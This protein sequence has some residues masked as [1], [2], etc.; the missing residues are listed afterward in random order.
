MLRKIVLVFGVLLILSAGNV[1]SASESI[2][3]NSFR[4]A[5]EKATD[6]FVELKNIGF[7]PVNI[8]GWQLAKKTASGTKYNLVTSFPSLEIMPGA[9]FVVG[10]DDSTNPTDLKYSSGN[11]ISEDNTIIIFS[12]AGKT[13]VDKVGFGKASDFEGVALPSAKTGIWTRRNSRDTDNNAADFVAEAT[14]LP[15]DLS[16]IQVTEIMIAPTDGNEWIEIYN[17]GPTIDIS[18]LVISD[19][20][21]SIRKYSVSPNTIIEHGGFRVF[22][23]TVTKISLNNTGDG[24]RLSAPDGTEIDNSGNSGPARPGQAYAFDGMLW[25][26]TAAPTPGA[27]NIFSGEKAT[28]STVT[29]K[30]VTKKSLGSAS[31]RKKK[32][33]ADKEVLGAQNSFSD[34]SVFADHKKGPRDSDRYLGAALIVLAILGGIA[35]T[36]YINKEKLVAIYNQERKGN[37]KN[38][39][40]FWA[41]LLRRG[42]FPSV[43]R[44][45]G[46][47]DAIYKRI[48]RRLKD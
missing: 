18:G 41:R 29:S 47:K 36:L 22:Y 20:A 42:N 31:S 37:Q 48:S 8:A 35:Y 4:V 44:F 9:S 17:S 2:V 34:D 39:Q 5:G 24:V 16:G 46:W 25:R 45:G 40:I 7:A 10:H 27:E 12:D 43:G 32:G 30:R 26:W 33:S 28:A 6:E 21:G 3:I 23:G 19:L 11:S 15:A 13:M 14:L 1:F 38:R